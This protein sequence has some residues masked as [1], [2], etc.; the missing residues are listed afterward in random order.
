MALNPFQQL[1]LIVSEPRQAFEDLSMMLLQ[2]SGK[3]D[4]RV[5]IYFGDGGVDGY[6]GDFSKNGQLTIYQSKYFTKPWNDSQKDKIR[7]SFKTA[8]TSKE[9]YLKEWFLCVPVRLT[10]QDLAWFDG[11]KA[12][13]SVP[14]DIVDGDDLT[15]MLATPNGARTR[16]Q[17]RNWGVFAV[18]DGSPVIQAKVR[19]LKCDPRAHQTYRLIILLENQGDRTAEGIRVKLG[20]SPTHCVVS[21]H[22]PDYWDD[23]GSGQLNPR[24]LR[25]K[26]DLHPGEPLEV[27]QIPLVAA[28]PFPFL[29]SIEYWLR[30][31]KSGRQ[32]FIL[33]EPPP[34]N[35]VIFDLYPGE[36]TLNA[37]VDGGFVQSTLKWPEDGC[38]DALLM[39]IARHP[40]QASALSILE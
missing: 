13:Q 21:R 19:C 23:F 31:Q 14:I 39:D 27:L 29:I 2:D 16:Q 22:N 40:R 30:D 11:W 5:A 18:R 37:S 33:T 3:I 7:D 6:T 28:T 36:L 25:S 4:G 8:A 35:D 32:S 12:K 15:Q 9:F 20:H 1:E 34:E 26:L 17:F 38:L 24:S 10:R